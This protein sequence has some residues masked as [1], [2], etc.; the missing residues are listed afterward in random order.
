MINNF[1]EN[2]TSLVDRDMFTDDRSKTH[3]T[4]FTVKRQKIKCHYLDG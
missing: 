4:I 2:H 3:A 1:N